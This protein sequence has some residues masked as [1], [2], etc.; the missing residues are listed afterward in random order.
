MDC[1][2]NT[3]EEA[4]EIFDRFDALIRG[5]A[6]K[7]ARVLCDFENCYHDPF[8]LM[9]WKKASAEHEPFVLKTAVTGVSGSFRIAMAAYRFFARL[10]GVEIDQIMREFPDPEAAKAWLIQ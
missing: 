7:S 10:S 4:Y 5:Q 9:K 6:P 8:I 3:K 2:S 1:S